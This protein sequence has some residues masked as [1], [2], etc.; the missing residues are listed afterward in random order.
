MA[1]IYI[2]DKPYMV[3]DGQN[4]LHAC[5]SLGF[6]IPYF[7]WHPAMHSVGACR[8]CA[9][10]QFKDE[11]DRRG[12]IVMSC[13]TPASDRTR[14]SINDPDA[15]AF[16]AAVLEWLMTNH[17]HDCPVC[18]EGGECHLQDMTV[19]TG[20]DYRRFRFKKRTHRNQDL[21]P[22]V[23][24]EMNRCI[25]CYRCVRFYR[26]Y[27]GGRDLEVFGSHN[28][29]YFGRE[30]D[31]VLENE[32]SGNLVEVCPTGVFTDKTLKRH[33]TRKWDLQTAPSV[34]VHCSLGCNTI[35]GE[36]YG[37]LRRVLNRYHGDL[38]GYFLCDRGRFGYEFV[39]SDHRIRGPLLRDRKGGL[40]KPISRKAALHHLS[41]LLHFGAGVIGIGSPRASLEANFALRSLVGPER[42]YSGSSEGEF[43]LVS[44]I[45]SIFENGPARS[46]SLKDV[47]EADAIFV[48][49]ED[50]ANTAPV[51]GLS[52]RQAARN[53]PMEKLEDL[54]ILEWNDAAVRTA[55]QDEK[56]PLFIAAPHSTRLDDVAL[57]TYH[58]P[59]D[60]L[61][62]LGFAVAQELGSHADLVSLSDE[63]V[64]SLA[65]EIAE[66]LKNA[67]RPLVVSGTGCGSK[68][69]V[70]AAANVAWSLCRIGR[71]AELCFVLPECNS[72]G[73]TLMA[74]KSV[75]EAFKV[76]REEAVETV[77]VLENDLF[78]RA[79]A[80]SV[81]AFFD[82]VKNIV[83]IDH[84]PNPTAARA[85]VVLPAATFAEGEGTLVNNEGRGQ[86]FYK[87]FIPGGEVRE[88]WRWL[89]DLMLSSGHLEAEIWRTF[90]D[91]TS[92]MSRALP[93]LGPLADAVPSAGFRVS[94]MEI[95]RRP[96]RYSGRTAMDANLSIHEPPSPDDPDSPLSFSMEGYSGMPPAP[97]IPRYWAPGWN[98]V[99]SLTKFQKEA[100][101]ALLGGDPGRRLIEPAQKGEISYFSD[102]PEAFK[103]TGD[104][105][106]IVPLYHVFGSEE[107]SI[108]SP[109]VYER[110]PEPY[111]ALS[112]GDAAKIG[113][114][115]GDDVELSL[116]G[117]VHR[118]RVS[119]MP[120]MTG[121]VGGLPVGLTALNMI[122]LPLLGRVKR[123]DKR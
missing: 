58:A 41:A 55:T 89:H 111:L 118:L 14:I 28:H 39:N 117:K 48:L 72:L 33:Y 18:D 2:D 27:A 46:P 104:G 93:V 50:V 67:R 10:K 73:L 9:V 51:L 24:H 68:V 21:G 7:C 25:Q 4:L 38:N 85:D 120:A 30:R 79:E 53:K 74:E 19:M 35:P 112:P 59:P 22:F 64:R 47:R 20:H 102:I 81:N 80:E 83:V 122:D 99:Q 29:V 36:R 37:L 3:K 8:Q 110:S 103:P 105:L 52:L 17:P 114:D 69:M 66:A 91:V 16:R 121:G 96:H 97:L 45:V 94:G 75:A 42:F 100:G 90:D 6:D 108:H 34:C 78:R 77:I 88:S 57:R 56:G 87:V 65:R 49:G 123:A 43:R 82:H 32:F 40:Q 70:H 116:S 13:M 62:L 54:G 60:D 23:N 12:K 84:L 107:L 101:G 63:G 31:G 15:K 76:A 44:E 115:D 98:S 26:G 119:L 61:A 5:L 106:L 1:T 109:G 71:P 113:V 95:P 92:A 11:K 86:R